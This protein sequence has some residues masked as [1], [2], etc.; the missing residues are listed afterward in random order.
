MGKTPESIRL[1]KQGLLAQVLRP[2][3][4]PKF[5]GLINCANVDSDIFFGESLRGIAKAKSICISCPALAQCAS[6]AIDHEEY[7]VFGGLS[8]KERLMMRGGTPAVTPLDSDRIRRE[9]LFMENA[10]AK[11]VGI[12]FGVDP[13]T[14]ARWRRALRPLKEAI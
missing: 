4:P 10:S 7:G 2:I 5:S 8:A 3:C 9:L 11:E 1:A 6:W 13:R 14:V 12:R